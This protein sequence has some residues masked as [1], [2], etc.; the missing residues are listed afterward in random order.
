MHYLSEY[1][2]SSLPALDLETNQTRVQYAGFWKQVQ[3]K[4]SL[5]EATMVRIFKPG[6][7]AEIDY[8]DGIEILDPVRGELRK[9]EFFVGVLCRSRYAFAQ[10]TWTQSSADFLEE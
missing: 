2:R 3:K 5:T 1:S 8:A 10:F 4:I 7:R 9:T 6:E